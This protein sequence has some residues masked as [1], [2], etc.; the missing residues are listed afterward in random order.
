M[1]TSRGSPTTS[2]SGKG[3]ALFT[4]EY[5]HTL[6]SKGR[7]SL[8]AAFRRDIPEGQTLY[9]FVDPEGAIRIYTRDA[10]GRWLDELFPK[11]RSADEEYNDE[12]T[13]G[14]NPR[15]R[16]DRAKRRQIA[17][18]TAEALLDSAGR[19]NVPEGLVAKAHIGHDVTVVGD[20]DHIELWDA[21]AWNRYSAD[22]GGSLDSLFDED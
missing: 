14:Y 8:P 9:L 5:N 11:R 18:A 12:A 10:Y 20:I 21:D 2:Y 22:S 17:A 19:V 7:I 4:G 1:T 13:N 6:D 16:S 3:A 15:S